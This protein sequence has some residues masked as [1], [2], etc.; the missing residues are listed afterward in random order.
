MVKGGTVT[1]KSNKIPIQSVF[2]W[3]SSGQDKSR[4]NIQRTRERNVLKVYTS[5][6][7]M[8]VVNFC[9][10]C[11]KNNSCSHALDYLFSAFHLSKAKYLK[12]PK[13]CVLE[14]RDTFRIVK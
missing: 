14:V 11:G 8:C 5:H 3:E 7:I 6:I 9:P 1:P 10:P 13:V 2:K 4:S 12:C